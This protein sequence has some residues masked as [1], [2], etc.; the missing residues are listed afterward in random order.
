MLPRE[1]RCTSIGGL[2][3]TATGIKVQKELE[4]K[5]EVL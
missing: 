1:L 4:E 2:C 3:A 5:R